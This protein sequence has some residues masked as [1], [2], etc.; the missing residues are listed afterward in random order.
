M[1]NYYVQ[2]R[3]CVLRMAGRS[4]TYTEISNYT[5]LTRGQVAGVLFRHRRKRRVRYARAVGQRLA[6][7]VMITT[8]AA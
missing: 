8:A 3:R 5:G 7:S 4:Y 2:L 6:D 1:S